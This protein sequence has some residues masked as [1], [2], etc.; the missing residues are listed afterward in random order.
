M[1]AVTPPEP[2]DAD[3]RRADPVR[4][5]GTDAALWRSC[6]PNKRTP[7]GRLLRTLCRSAGQL[8]AD[9]RLIEPGDRVL[10]AISGGK[11]SYT[12]LEVLLRLQ[13]KARVEFELG[14]IVVQPGFPGFDAE[15]AAR[16]CAERGVQCYLVTADIFETMNDLGWR[17]APCAMCS[18]LRRGVLYRVSQDLGY[19]TLALGHHGDDAI[20]TALLNMLFNG[21]LRAMAPRSVPKQATPVVIR[22]LL[23]SFEATVH[24]YATAR[25][26]KPVATACPLCDVNME[27]ERTAIKHLLLELEYHHPRVRSSLLA[28]LAN[29]S[30]AALMDQLLTKR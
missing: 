20:E 9:Y 28:S 2:R 19:T 11:D 22:P 23:A 10:C 30:P 8:I 25:G 5:C 26:F 1:S 24:Q 27:S 17:D 6:A 12:M 3:L 15:A 13:A 18:R 4:I 21:Q 7:A 14:A 16:F 29:V